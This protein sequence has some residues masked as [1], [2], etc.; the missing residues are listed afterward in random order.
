M[1][2][3]SPDP[4]QLAVDR[5]RLVPKREDSASSVERGRRMIKGKGRAALEP[6]PS[7]SLGWSTVP[8]HPPARTGDGWS[9]TPAPASQP[10]ST[11]WGVV[12]PQPSRDTQ[13]SVD[14]ADW[15]WGETSAKKGTNEDVNVN[16]WGWGEGIKQVTPHP[17]VGA[18]IGGGWSSV[19]ARASQRGSVR[20]PLPMDNRVDLPAWGWGE[21]GAKQ[22]TNGGSQ[23]ELVAWGGGRAQAQAQGTATAVDLSGWE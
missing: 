4:T 17:L 14:L 21:T 10:V 15:G 5:R 23:E 3:P 12:L 1:R 16:A 9:T 19:P 22:A 20:S 18:G 8:S 6:A 11:G 13:E 2:S 7:A